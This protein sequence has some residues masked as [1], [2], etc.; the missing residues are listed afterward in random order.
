MGGYSYNDLS[1]KTDENSFCTGL[2]PCVEIDR[3]QTSH[4]DDS[5]EE[6]YF[7]CQCACEIVTYQICLYSCWEFYKSFLS[8]L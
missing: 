2:T 1:V 4:E 5:Y 3:V 7:V 8:D 6:R